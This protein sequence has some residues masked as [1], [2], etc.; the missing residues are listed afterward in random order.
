MARKIQRK[1]VREDVFGV[2]IDCCGPISVVIKNLQE[3]WQAALDKGYR[4]IQ[5]QDAGPDAYGFFLVGERDES[6]KEY[7]RRV[8]K[9]KSEKAQVEAAERAQLAR[10]AGK[11]GC[12]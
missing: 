12:P 7:E 4:D 3:G 2:S 5:I 1:A 8:R 9:I 10:L 11:Y 6:D